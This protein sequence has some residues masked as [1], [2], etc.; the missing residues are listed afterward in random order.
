M[1]KHK[2]VESYIEAE[3]RWQDELVRLREILLS[4]ELEEEVKWG[5]PCYT[6]DGKNVVGLGA[7]K[8]YFALWFYQGALLTDEQGVLINAQEGKTRA[9]RQWRFESGRE[10]KVRPIKAYV[11][12]AIGL[13]ERGQEIKPQRKGALRL[14]EELA[15]ALAK[16]KAAKA[17]F[18]GLTPGKQR[19][20]AEYIAEAKRE[21]TKAKR[22]EKVL[23]M[24][25]AGQGLNDRYRG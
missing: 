14:P 16:S 22:V 2:T 4:T 3:E 20:Y 13:V 21:A 15:S 18:E 9:L 17:A 1:K 5:A 23:P 11:A 6:Y 24:I 7:F 19:E 25:R 12:E 10:I 8:P